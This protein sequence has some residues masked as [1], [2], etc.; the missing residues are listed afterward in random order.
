[1]KRKFA[2]Y[3]ALEERCKEAERVAEDIKTNYED[4]IQQLSLN[5]DELANKWKQSEEDKAQQL[6]R[7]LVVVNLCKN[8]SA[9]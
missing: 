7:K 5:C 2:Q 6:E 3:E 8:C 9:M 4:K 1:M